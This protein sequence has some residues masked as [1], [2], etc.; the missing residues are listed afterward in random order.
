MTSP[1]WPGTFTINLLQKASWAPLNR[2]VQLMC[3]LEVSFLLFH[4]HMCM[5]VHMHVLQICENIY[6]G[7][8][9]HVYTYGGLKLGII[10]NHSS[11]LFIG[12][13]SLNQTQSSLMWLVPLAACSEYPLPI[14]A[15]WS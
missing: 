10:L 5:Y 13:G 7:A 9:E 1:V 14:S 12:P 15:F 6:V 4:F 2:V 8:H 3:T 11:M